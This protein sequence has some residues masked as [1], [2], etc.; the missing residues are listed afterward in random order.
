MILSAVKVDLGA[1]ALTKKVGNMNLE[2]LKAAEEQFFNE[3]PEGFG[4][5][6]FVDIIKRHNVDKLSLFAKEELSK[7]KF[8]DTN[9]VVAAAIKIITTSSMVSVFEKMRFRDYSKS[10]TRMRKKTFAK[11]FYEL[12]HGDQ[13]KGF[14]LLLSELERHKLAKWTIISAVPFYYKPKKEYFIKPMTT[15]GVISRLEL[16]LEY[17]PKPTWAFYKKYRTALNK[18]K[19]AVDQE[20]SPNHAAF[21]G[22]LMMSLEEDEL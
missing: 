1:R 7:E 17:K 10:L 22:F 13:Q 19:K 21:T 4:S 6:E 15:K 12:L 3:Y 18:M 11:G 2:T 20:L 16:D 8:E 9:K 14:E 5:P